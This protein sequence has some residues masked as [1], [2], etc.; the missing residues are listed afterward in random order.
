MLVLFFIRISY[1]FDGYH[2]ACVAGIFHTLFLHVISP[3]FHIRKLRLRDV[4]SLSR[5]HIV[6]KQR[7]RCESD[8]VIQTGLFLGIVLPQ[9]WAQRI[10]FWDVQVKLFNVV[11]SLSVR[12]VLNSHFNVILIFWTSSSLWQ[13]RH[14]LNV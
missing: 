14:S 7:G 1:T 11:G 3:A 13:K 6:S 12:K 8:A 5:S 4:S 9:R 10:S 2:C